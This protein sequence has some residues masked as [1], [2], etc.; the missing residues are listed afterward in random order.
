MTHEK[1]AQAKWW[2][3]VTDLMANGLAHGAEKVQRA[4]LSIADESFNVLAR[5]PVTRPVSEPVRAMHHG[6]S[7][8]SY[9]SVSRVAGALA[10]CSQ[11]V[12]TEAAGSDQQPSPEASPQD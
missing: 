10:A 3:G 2:L 8:L 9:G 12:L 4:H 6:I 1:Q 5:I 11:Q 7:R